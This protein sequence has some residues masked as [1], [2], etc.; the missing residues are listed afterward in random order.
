MYIDLVML[1]NFLV[2]FLLLLGTNRLAGYPPGT[3]RAALAAA[4]GG[5]YS[6][7]CLLPEVRFL[8][9]ILW[10]MVSLGFISVIAFGFNQSAVRRCVLF[11]ILSLALGGIAQGMDRNGFVSLLAGAGFVCL[12]CVVGFQGRAGAHTYVPVE[13][14]YGGK[15]LRITALRDSG[16]TLRDPVTGQQVLV[17]GAEV[18]RQLTG[19]TRQ[20][21]E[22]PVESMGVIPG[23]RLI[24]YRTVGNPG[25]MLLALRIPETRIGTWKG[26]AIVAF[27][28]DGI[29]AGKEYQALTGGAA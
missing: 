1:L 2:D 4:F 20:Q 11:I 18:A 23:L 15:R 21:L 28:P 26:S 14:R 22:R 6:G 10:R 9:N 27:A 5:V 29:G 12:L 17:V 24:P 16:N 7:V 8:G 13:L 3:G 25:G 19:L